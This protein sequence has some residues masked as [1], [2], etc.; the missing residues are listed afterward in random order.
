MRKSHE[1]S[2]FL[3]ENTVTYMYMCTYKY[4]LCM[5]KCGKVLKLYS[6]KVCIFLGCDCLTK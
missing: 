1:I 5:Q 2:A 6:K 3:A 4:V